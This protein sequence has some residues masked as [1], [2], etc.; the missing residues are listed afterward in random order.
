[1]SNTTTVLLD[2]RF[3][4]TLDAWVE[5]FS[6]PVWRGASVQAW[7]FEGVAARRAAERQLAAAGVQ[8]HLHS[9]YK[10]LV[11]YFLEDVDASLLAEVTVHYPV[12]AQASPQRFL[13]EAY[14]LAALLR[15][16]KLRFVPGSD[17]LH[18]LVE[19]THRDGTQHLARVFAPNRMHTDL[20]GIELLSPTGWVRAT[21]ASTTQPT[22]DS[23]RQTDYEALFDTVLNTV[24]QH[25]WCA[26]APYFER[27]DIRIDMPGIEQRLPVGHETIS[28]LEGLHEDIYFS[29]KMI[30]KALVKRH[31]T[32]GA[33]T[34]DQIIV[35][36][37]QTK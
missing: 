19:S 4:R 15:Q 16:C 1:M 34:I 25:P 31:R 27:L 10:P 32:L 33:F 11:F 17:D 12:H 14:P 13:Q 6:N 37:S 35:S 8:A 30:I 28:S 3:P 2:Q 26:E 23:A 36:Q 9:A 24:D 21:P 18:Y 29:L 5:E 7:L 22:V 20:Q